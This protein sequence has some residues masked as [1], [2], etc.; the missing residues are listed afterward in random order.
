MKLLD[1]LKSGSSNLWRNKGRTI[2]TIIAIFIGAFT[3][4][5]TRGINVGVNTYIDQ[6]VA[7]VGGENQMMVQPA[8]ESGNSD[9][10]SEYQ[11]GEQGTA[12]ADYLTQSD[13]DKIAEIKNIESVEP[14]LLPSIDYIQGNTDKKYVLNSM[15]DMDLSIELEAGAA[16]D[17][18]DSAYQ[19]LLAPEYLDSLG[20]SSAED[21][22]GKTVTLA[23]T[24][25]GTGE[26]ETV[27]AT[28][29]GVR[30]ASL[31]NGGQ[32]IINESLA[33]DLLAI[34]EDGLPNTL[35]GRYYGATATM[36][37]GLSDEEVADIE[38]ALSDADMMG[39]T[40]EEEIGSI[41]NVINAITAV[42]TMFGGIA[43][44]AASFGIINTLYMSVQDRTREIGLMKAMGLSNGKIFLTFSVEALLIGFWGSVLGILGAIG[45]SGLIN[46]WAQDSFLSGLDGLTLLQ[47]N[48][49]SIV[50]IIV[51]IML[52]AFLA[53]TFPANR[54]ARLDP[55]EALRYE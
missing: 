30:A 15:M 3:I 16:I 31:I 9:G 54:A 55:I 28:I 21:A 19:I 10:P 7:G 24:A 22:G 49:A 40:V 18:N 2:L 44:L 43:L 20:F 5:L 45:I 29:V 33:K 34:N 46:N 13:L 14:M 17:S 52:I 39:M 4:A 36:K 8:Y 12:E 42:L 37:D 1:I 50:M 32:S 53:G 51:V 27:E 38:S 25:Q 11:E 41:R 35:T 48:P 6:Q 23:A 26:Q 47:Y